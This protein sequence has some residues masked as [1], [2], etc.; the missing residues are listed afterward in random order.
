[1]QR[2]APV[3]CDGGPVH[4]EGDGRKRAKQSAGAARSRVPVPRKGEHWRR[5][6][7]SAVATEC[8][9]GVPCIVVSGYGTRVGGVLYILAQMWE[10]CCLRALS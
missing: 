9:S 1:M 7:E 4:F 2:G 3:H 5:A 10:Q 8:G 6:E